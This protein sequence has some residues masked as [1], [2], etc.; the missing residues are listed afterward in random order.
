[1]GCGNT[2]T[3]PMHQENHDYDFQRTIENVQM[4]WPPIKKI[5]NLG[6]KIFAR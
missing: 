2:K 1:M 4:T 5:D 6:P 3:S